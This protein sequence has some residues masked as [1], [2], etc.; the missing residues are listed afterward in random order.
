MFIIENTK[1][2]G[3]L[4]FLPYSCDTFLSS[5]R[6]LPFLLTG[7]SVIREHSFSILCGWICF[8]T[9]PNTISSL[10]PKI[11]LLKRKSRGVRIDADEDIALNLC[12]SSEDFADFIDSSQFVN[13]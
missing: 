11:F 9:S 3:Y 8:S 7:T 13:F 10:M 4:L 12:N 1:C 5:L 6:L 2:E